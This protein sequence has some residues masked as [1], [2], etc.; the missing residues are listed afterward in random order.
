MKQTA[1]KLACF[2]HPL[3]SR[4]NGRGITS[5]VSHFA[6]LSPFSSLSASFFLQKR[7]REP[8]RIFFSSL[9]TAHFFLPKSAV[10]K[11]MQLSHR[12]TESNSTSNVLQCVFTMF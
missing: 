7:E 9:I 11:L 12:T 2:Q 10:L 1:R 8:H 5:F 4:Q 3:Y 6:F